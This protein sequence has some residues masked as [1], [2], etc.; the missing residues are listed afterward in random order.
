MK[1]IARL[2]LA[3]TTIMSL[4]GSAMAMRNDCMYKVTSSTGLRSVNLGYMV[5]QL[6]EHVVESPWDSVCSHH[7]NWFFGGGGPTAVAQLRI[8]ERMTFE[9]GDCYAASYQ[10][11]DSMYSTDPAE[12]NY[13]ITTHGQISPL[14]SLQGMSDPANGVMVG[15][16]KYSPLSSAK[17]IKLTPNG[18]P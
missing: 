11:T 2:A 13:G 17:Q 8:L 14:Y 1:K 18:C 5:A 12:R 4:S 16:V 9:W 10:Y 7:V 15:M 3:F 6:E